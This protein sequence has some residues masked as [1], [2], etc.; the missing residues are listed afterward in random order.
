[1]TH[2]LQWLD[3]NNL[4]DISTGQASAYMEDVFKSSFLN[5]EDEEFQM[6]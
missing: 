5:V 1:M 3:E 4:K 6:I 2:L